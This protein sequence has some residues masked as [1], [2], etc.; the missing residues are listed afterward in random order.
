MSLFRHRRIRIRGIKPQ[1]EIVI[2]PRAHDIDVRVQGYENTVRLETDSYR[3][4]VS[5]FGVGNT[6]VIEDGVWVCKPCSITIGTPATPCFNCT[7][8]IGRETY[9][10]EVDILCGEDGSRIE[11]GEHCMFSTGMKIWCTDGHTVC[12]EDGS[13]NIGRHVRIGQRVWVGMDV[14]VGKNTIIADDCMVGWG[15]V[16]TGRFEEPH[17]LLA[18]VP[19]RV[20]RRGITWDN[21]RPMQYSGESL[22]KQYPDWDAEPLPGALL[23]LW[24]RAKMAWFRHLAAHKSDVQ[25]RR[26]YSGKAEA[27]AKR[28]R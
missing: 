11:I 12:R 28:L 4:S 21:R 15:S 2:S 3:G 6:V 17:C 25:K 13:I 10:G 9:L 1:R 5:V 26:K 16:V 19:A 14:K 8:I 18:G 23:R 22:E 7:V 24:L 20:C 27:I